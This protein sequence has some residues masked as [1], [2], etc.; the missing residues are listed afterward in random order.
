MQLPQRLDRYYVE[1][2]NRVP[3][4]SI[5]ICTSSYFSPLP[6]SLPACFFETNAELHIGS[7]GKFLYGEN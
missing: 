4:H 7:D 1:E 5:K 6:S 2:G 3:K